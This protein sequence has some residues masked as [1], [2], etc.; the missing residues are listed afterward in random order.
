MDFW[1]EVSSC[2]SRPIEAV[3]WTNEIESAKSIADLKTS[4]SV[5][6][7]KL[8]SNFGVIGW[9][10][11]S[12]RTLTETVSNTNLHRKKNAFSR[13]APFRIYFPNQ[14]RIKVLQNLIIFILLRVSLY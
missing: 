11:V 3:V 12:R 4:H 10:M 13:Q 8:Q 2:A 14:C 9:R 6:G 7:A 5:T 1:P